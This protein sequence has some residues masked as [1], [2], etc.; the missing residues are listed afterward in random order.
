MNFPFGDHRPIVACSTGWMQNTAIALIRLSG[1]NDFNE[2]TKFFA[3]S[4]GPLS[5][6]APRTAVFCQLMEGAKAL[7]QGVLT[8]FKAPH[9]F[10]GENL[11]E[12][13]VHG[14]Q[15]NIQRI[16]ELFISSGTFRLA[17]PGE[18]T[19]RALKNKKISLSEVEGLDL[20]LNAPSKGVL[21]QAI[22]LIGGELTQAYMD[23]RKCFLKLKASIELSMDFLEDVG[24]KSARESFFLS[25]EDF[26]AQLSSLQRKTQSPISSI[27][28]P[29]IVLV[30]RPNTGKSSLF[31]RFLQESRSIVSSEEGTTRD[32]IA[33]YISLNDIQFRLIDTAGLRETKQS[34]ERQG[35]AKSVQLIQKAFFKILLINPA[36]FI[37]EELAPI[38]EIDFDLI[39]LTHADGQ[40]RQGLHCH[41]PFQYAHYGSISLRPGPIGPGEVD[42]KNGP[43]GPLEISPIGPQ[44]ITP[45][46]ELIVNKY[47][48]LLKND[49]ILIPRQRWI[50][51]E[52]WSK[53][54]EFQQLIEQE[55]DMAIISSE[56]NLI[57]HLVEE[58]IGVTSVD[59]SLESVFSKFCIGK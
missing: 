50:I 19:Y 53:L 48:K 49:E 21:D 31:N 24:E 37:W 38:K 59:D 17:Q 1:F 14:N 45:I 3:G 41:F 57:G 9:S 51:Q 54:Q 56:L 47:L 28:S 36:T 10:T 5:P 20:F 30:G 42:I 34:I 12:L 2:L 11:L 15:I 27:T 33:E 46:E 52:S 35:I 58:L 26:S 29:D 32:Y 18:F 39:L 7:D 13:G 44:K 8:Y 23:L 4:I 22:K 43:I 16:L 40:G 25:L 55:L 6:P